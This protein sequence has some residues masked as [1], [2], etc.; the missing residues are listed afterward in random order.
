[1]KKGFTL[2]ELLGVMVILSV[3]VSISFPTVIG[4]I[5]EKKQKSEE[6]E[7]EMIENAVKLYTKDNPNALDKD[8]ILISK[9]QKGKYLKS[10]KTTK[11]YIKKDGNGYKL[12]DNC[13]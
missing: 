10:V 12:V 8:C 1:M 6:Y 9:L 13:Q 3:I 11:Q 4:V 7:F 5:K 2:V